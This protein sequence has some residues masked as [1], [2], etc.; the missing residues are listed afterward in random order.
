MMG[1]K[2]I[3]KYNKKLDKDQSALHDEDRTDLDKFDNQQFADDIPMDDLN[4]EQE[5][6]KKNT[7]TKNDSQ[8]EKKFKKYDKE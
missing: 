5:E 4:M 2:E 8:S 3:D 6:E 7:K 1:D